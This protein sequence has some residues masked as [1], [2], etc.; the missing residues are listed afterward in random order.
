VNILAVSIIYIALLIMMAVYLRL[1]NGQWWQ[2][3]AAAIGLLP[4]SAALS[5]LMNY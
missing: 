5:F 1:A 4:I 2:L 3:F